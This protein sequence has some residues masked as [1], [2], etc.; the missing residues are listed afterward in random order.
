MQIRPHHTSPTGF[1]LAS[2][3]PA[4]KIQDRDASQQDSAGTSS[5][6]L[7]ELYQQVVELAGRRHLRSAASSKLSAQR[8]ATTV[9]RR[10]FAVSGP[11]I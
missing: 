9:G 3:S 10:N 1:A 7:A 6:Y 4:D 2:G 8:T 11:D 5:P